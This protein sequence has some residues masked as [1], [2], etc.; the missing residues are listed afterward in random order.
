MRGL[1]VSICLFARVCVSLGCA[2]LCADLSLHLSC[3]SVA[4][5][6]VPPLWVLRTW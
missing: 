4:N 3:V 1:R 6:Q 5:E 2:D